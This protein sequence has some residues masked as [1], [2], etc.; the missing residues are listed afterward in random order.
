L[1]VE[2][3]KKRL[4]LRKVPIKGE[5]TGTRS[6][7]LLI[8]LLRNWE[9]GGLPVDGGEKKAITVEEGKRGTKIIWWEEGFFCFFL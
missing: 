5:K 6:S 3:K 8:P 1:H 4:S 9:E 7:Y 2:K